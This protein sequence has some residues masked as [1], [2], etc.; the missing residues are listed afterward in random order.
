VFF[1]GLD[2]GAGVTALA[3]AEDLAMLFERICAAAFGGEIEEVEAVDAA[4]E[5]INEGKGLGLTAG[6]VE[7]GV[8]F[9]IGA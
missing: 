7:S 6:G 8:K 1:E 9:L 3:G 4:A 5:L 2:G